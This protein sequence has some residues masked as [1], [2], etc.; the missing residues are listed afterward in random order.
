METTMGK[1]EAPGKHAAPPISVE[2]VSLD[3]ANPKINVRNRHGFYEATPE[4]MDAVLRWWAIRC[5]PPIQI[6]RA[7][8]EER[9]ISTDGVEHISELLVMAADCMTFYT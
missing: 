2:F 6:V 3:P 4:Q 9:G 8:L 7:A 1:H 5:C